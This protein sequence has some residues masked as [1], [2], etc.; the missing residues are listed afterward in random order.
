MNW[1]AV[2]RHNRL[3]SQRKA[4]RERYAAEMATR[5]ETAGGVIK[6]DELRAASRREEKIPPEKWYSI[7]VW[8]FRGKDW[9]IRDG[10][11][12]PWKPYRYEQCDRTEGVPLTSAASKWIAA[13]EADLPAPA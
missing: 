9:I 12:F 7:T 4:K 8:N 13:Q 2:R 5:I 10:A 6:L 1:A 3:A 11:A